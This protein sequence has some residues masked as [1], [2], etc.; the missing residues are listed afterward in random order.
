MEAGILGKG[1]LKRWRLLASPHGARIYTSSPSAFLLWA[2][3]VS[4]SLCSFSLRPPPP[5]LFP[6]HVSLTLTSAALNFLTSSSGFGFG[7]GA[8]ENSI[9]HRG[10]WG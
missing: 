9:P 3:V 2:V 10:P 1:D 6:P 7:A 8:K 5:Y 4:L